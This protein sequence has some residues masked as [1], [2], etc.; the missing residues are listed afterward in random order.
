MYKTTLLMRVEQR[1][2]ELSSTKEEQS[3][4]TESSVNCEEAH[5]SQ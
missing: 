1:Y 4:K 2:A 5:A 3:S